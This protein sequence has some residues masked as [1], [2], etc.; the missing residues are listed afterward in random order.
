M[1]KISLPGKVAVVTGGARGIGK[2][3][4][5]RLLEKGA[6][7][8]SHFQVVIL[9]ILKDEGE[10][11]LKDLQEKFGRDNVY[12]YYCDVTNGKLF[13]DLLK[14]INKDIGKLDIM[15]NNAGV[16][17][18]DDW[19]QTIHINLIG[20]I[21]GTK[22][23]TELM[24]RDKGGNGGVILNMSS[25]AGLEPFKGIETY[26]ATKHGLVGFTKT[27]ALNSEDADWGIRYHCMCPVGVDTALVHK[28]KQITGQEYF[29]H[30]VE[31]TGGLLSIEGLTEEFLKMILYSDNRCLAI[32]KPTGV[33]YLE[34]EKKTN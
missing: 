1:E 33:Q 10:A 11:S 21:R 15:V 34:M 7:L 14:S 13:E 4:V 6:K 8:P 3:F 24:R 23:A 25:I 17:N 30:A 28:L 5:Q 16:C 31:K 26:C 20:V 27:M 32:V 12:F 22:Q 19:E 9:D 18:E 29:D 2:A